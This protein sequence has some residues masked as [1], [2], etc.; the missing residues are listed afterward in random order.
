MGF[1]DVERWKH[2]CNEILAALKLKNLESA[3]EWLAKF[4]E[5]NNFNLQ[6]GIDFYNNYLK[7]LHGNFKIH[8]DNFKV[9]ESFKKKA[10]HIN[11]ILNRLNEL[12]N[13]GKVRDE[14][15]TEIIHPIMK[16]WGFRKQGRSFIKGKSKNIVKIMIYSSKN[17][18]YYNVNFRF[19]IHTKTGGF[20][21]DYGYNL[22]ENTDIEKIKAEIE[23]D[24]KGPI[25]VILDKY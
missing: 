18:D 8:I 16:S 20:P 19:E 1:K 23:A 4:E 14:M 15:I 10:A 13:M 3:N 24:L 21:T 5:E 6:M 9:E 7:T 12:K 25:K 2:Y 22:D 11:L 17:N